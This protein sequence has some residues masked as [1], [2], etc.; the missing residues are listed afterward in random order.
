MIRADWIA[1]LRAALADVERLLDAP[2]APDAGVGSQP[3][4]DTERPPFEPPDADAEPEIE[5]ERHA[6]VRTWATLVRTAE[7]GALDACPLVATMFAAVACS[8]EGAEGDPPVMGVLMAIRETV[9]GWSHA[10]GESNVFAPVAYADLLLMMRRIDVA[11]ALVKS[12]AL[13]RGG[14]R[15]AP[16]TPAS[17]CRVSTARRRRPPLP[18]RSR[19]T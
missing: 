2:P 1:S 12:D 11:M 7:D 4:T 6:I 15:G 17:A 10:E 18:R 16:P 13:R 14:G 5:A 19:K 3:T 8:Y 9:T